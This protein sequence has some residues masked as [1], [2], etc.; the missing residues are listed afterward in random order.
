MICDTFE[1]S[2]QNYRIKSEIAQADASPYFLD[3]GK[4]KKYLFRLLIKLIEF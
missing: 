3:T 1:K 4:M 2:P